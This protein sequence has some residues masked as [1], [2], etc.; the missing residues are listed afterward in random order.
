[1]APFDRWDALSPQSVD[2]LLAQHG[3]R[4][5]EVVVGDVEQEALRAEA[6]D[7]ASDGDGL[8][9]VETEYEAFSLYRTGLSEM[10]AVVAFGEDSVVLGASVAA[11]RRTVETK[12]GDR[13][14]HYEANSQFRAVLSRT[15][16]EKANDVDS[17]LGNAPI[18]RVWPANTPNTFEAAVGDVQSFHYFLGFDERYQGSDERKREMTDERLRSTHSAPISISDV[19]LDG[20]V[21][22]ATAGMTA[23]FRRTETGD[24]HLEV[25]R[26]RENTFERKDFLPRK[27][28]FAR[29]PD[30]GL[31]VK[32][33]TGLHKLEPDSGRFSWTDQPAMHPA[34]IQIAENGEIFVE[35]AQDDDDFKVLNGRNGNDLTYGTGI[36]NTIYYPERLADGTLYGAANAEA[37]VV[38]APL[39][40]GERRWWFEAPNDWDL[41]VLA[42][43]PEAVAVLEDDEPRIV[44]LLDA[45]S[46][47]IQREWSYEVPFDDGENR[48]GVTPVETDTHVFINRPEPG[49]GSNTPGSLWGVPL[50]PDGEVASVS[51]EGPLPESVPVDDIESNDTDPFK[52]YTIGS[53]V[54]GQR[55]YQ[56]FHNGQ[57]FAASGDVWR[58]GGYFEILNLE[59]TSS[60]GL[61]TSRDLLI[62][63]DHPLT[64][65]P[66]VTD[67]HVY[68]QDRS[69]L[70]AVARDSGERVW[71]S[72]AVPRLQDA[73]G[74]VDGSRISLLTETGVYSLSDPTA[75]IGLPFEELDHPPA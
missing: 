48:L 65:L 30:G 35:G 44:Y 57:L 49:G 4:P 71:E 74:A 16:E 5:V 34:T 12:T 40:A 67:G 1:M 10:D 42:A 17:P 47:S 72:S 3:D 13:E 66:A 51:L 43:T 46:G 32:T 70:Y 64:T 6:R 11:V 45:A 62:E 31:V 27:A 50:S 38:A 22:R 28:G 15:V 18:R 53:H 8:D 60:G 25:A 69:G 2:Y 24:W 61:E 9:A 75:D 63:F 55:R 58:D 23:E 37:N 7:R 68:L 29:H 54:R 21:T 41:T 26:V 14:R 39:G 33:L 73:C 59:T 20:P 19:A 36:E 56:E 52:S